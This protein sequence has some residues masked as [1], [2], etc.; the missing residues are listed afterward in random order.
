MAVPPL[1]NFN[2]VVVSVSI[3]FPTN[4]KRDVLFHCIAFDYSSA[5]WHGFRDHLRNVPWE[6]PFK[7]TASAAAS[8]FFE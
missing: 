1:G 2:H 5:D 8:K 7:L 4:S 3:D 6:D